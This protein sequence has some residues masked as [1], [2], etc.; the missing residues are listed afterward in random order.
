M[1]NFAV[2]STKCG[3]SLWSVYEGL[4]FQSTP[5]RGR[6]LEVQLSKLT[7]KSFQSTPPRGRRPQIQHRRYRMHYFNPRLREGGDI[8]KRHRL[9]QFR[10]FNP[11]LREG[12]DLVLWL[13][14]LC[15]AISIHASAREATTIPS[16]TMTA[17]RFQST[18]P[19]GRRQRVRYLI[20]DIVTFQSTPPRGRRHIKVL[21]YNSAYYFNPRLREGGDVG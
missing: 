15:F 12:G 18:P 6:R 8:F 3:K 7:T 13:P 2:K 21:S 11:R 17:P 10:Y 1:N 5:P 19:R 9:G 16:I 4:A 14:A 20:I